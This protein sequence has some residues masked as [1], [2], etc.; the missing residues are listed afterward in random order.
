MARA[1]IGT[2]AARKPKEGARRTMP[3]TT[4]EGETV[5]RC[6]KGDYIRK[7]ERYYFWAVGF[8][9]SRQYACMKHPPRPSELDGSIFSAVMA[10]QEDAAS[11][12]AGIDTG[13]KPDDI[14][15]DVE[16]AVQLVKD[17]IESVAEQY[18]DAAEAMGGSSGAGAQMEEWA[19]NLEG[20]GVVDWRVE[21]YSEEPEPCE[22]HADEGEPAEGCDAC[23]ENVVSWANSLIEEAGSQIDDVSKE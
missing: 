2:F 16:S 8:R 6:R 9:G 15:A 4:V 1:H 19:E 3:T 7:G 14:K 18:R 23:D 10:A 17:A 11:Q 21:D 5:L 20:A 22:D 13:G 12:L